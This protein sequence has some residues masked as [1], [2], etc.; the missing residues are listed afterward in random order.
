V[1]SGRDAEKLHLPAF[2]LNLL[3]DLAGE[4]RGRHRIVLGRG[5]EHRG[6]VEQDVHEIPRFRL[7]LFLLVRLPNNGFLLL[8]G[9]PVGA[10]VGFEGFLVVRLSE[11]ASFAP[12]LQRR[13][14]RAAD[15][16]GAPVV[17]ATSFNTYR[18]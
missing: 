11:L 12:A 13:V 1:P 18:K 6:R 10:E 4:R 14:N 2:S 5:D 7:L 3:A 8:A 9:D 15:K 16:E 17:G